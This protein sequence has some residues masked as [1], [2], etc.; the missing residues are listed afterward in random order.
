MS[1]GVLT[2]FFQGNLELV[3]GVLIETVPS[4]QSKNDGSLNIP[5]STM[6]TWDFFCVGYIGALIISIIAMF[7]LTVWFAKYR[8]KNLVLLADL[9]R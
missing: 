8:V 9:V 6:S 2:F 5:Q 7:L 3:N 4:T 1:T